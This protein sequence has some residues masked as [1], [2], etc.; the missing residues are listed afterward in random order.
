MARRPALGAPAESDGKRPVIVWIH[1]G[2][3]MYGTGEMYGPDRLAAGGAVVVSMNYRLG[4]MGFLS[5]P[6]VEG[7]DGLGLE[8]A[9]AEALRTGRFNRVPVLVG[10]DH[11]EE[12]G[13]V[14]GQELAPGGAPMKP[15]EYEPAVREQFGDRADA[16]LARYPLS[17][18]GSAGEALAAVRTDSA[19]SVPTLDTA[20][21]LAQWTRPV[22]TSSASAA[23]PG[24]GGIRHRAS[25]SVPSTC[26][27]WPTCST[28]TCSRT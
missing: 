12:R 24:S 13:A 20:R 23:H 5:G 2:S 7:A 3:L 15:D 27:S 16:V 14:L 18:F 21:L 19:W 25:S 17:A 11:D 28:W 9:P 4:V 6:A 22:W 1:G 10:V 8:E 26:P